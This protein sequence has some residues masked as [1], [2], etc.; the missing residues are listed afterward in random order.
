VVKSRYGEEGWE[1]DNIEPSGG[2]TA[3]GG[4][5][6]KKYCEKIAGHRWLLLDQQLYR[7][8]GQ[9]MNDFVNE[10][11]VEIRSVGGGL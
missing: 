3:V 6:I 11:H 4:V 8:P 9:S 1:C 5:F 7:H 2:E 10:T